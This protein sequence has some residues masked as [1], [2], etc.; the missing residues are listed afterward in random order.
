VRTPGGT[1]D[2]ALVAKRFAVFVDGCFWHG[3]PEHYVCPRTR[4]GFWDEKLREN[5]ERD[6]RQMGRL[7]QA[8]WTAVRVWEHDLRVAPDRVVERVMKAFR[9]GGRGT[10]PN[11]RVVSVTPTDASWRRERRLACQLVGGRTR[12]TE[13]PRTTAKTGRVNRRP[14][15]PSCK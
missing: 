6:R 1:A 15:A 11:W 12:E 3:C 10:W 9:K 14:A 4:T 13:G 5:V 2:L 7:L 8:G